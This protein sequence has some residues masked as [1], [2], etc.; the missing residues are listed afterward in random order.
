L[1]KGFY[2]RQCFLLA[3]G[4][5][6]ISRQTLYLSLNAVEGFDVLEA[7]SAMGAALLMVSSN[8]LRRA[9]AQQ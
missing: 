8:S 9:G 5:A 2:A 7:L 6:F 3:N 4:A 1:F